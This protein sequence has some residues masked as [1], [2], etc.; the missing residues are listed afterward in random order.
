MAVDPISFDALLAP[1]PGEHPTGRP[2]RDKN[3][4]FESDF[5]TIRD[6]ANEARSAERKLS[7]YIP[8]VHGEEDPYKPLPPNWNAVFTTAIDILSKK[9]KDL[10]VTA[11]LIEA[12]CRLQGFAGL[13]DGFRLARELCERYWGALHPSGPEGDLEHL[14]AQVSGLNGTEGEGT[15][16]PPIKAIPITKVGSPHPYSYGD[17]V[18]ASQLEQ[19]AN[20]ERRQKRIA[21]GEVS[22]EQ[23]E[24]AVADS[25][26]D[27]YVELLAAVDATILEFSQL[28]Q[29]LEDRCRLPDSGRSCAPPSS[30]IK[31]VLTEIRHR[32]AILAG[33]DE[34]GGKGSEDEHTGDIAPGAGGGAAP[35]SH[36]TAGQIASRDDAFRRILSI[37]EYFEKA[38]PHS[39]VSY[40]LRQVVRWG[41]LSLPDLLMQL[42]DNSDTRDQLFRHIGIEKPTESDH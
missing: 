13:R 7:S 25:T 26:R 19:D 38:E 11:W 9:S 32:V 39:P 8:P 30:N 4:G 6:A 24:R 16:I 33:E 22:L 2:I 42:I 41:R 23:F 1:I 3:S 31:N 27:Y 15:L 18:A 35:A 20:P 5:Y 17:F 28:C 36:V 29:V 40:G 14:L 37:A 34:A 12:L 21:D 10:W